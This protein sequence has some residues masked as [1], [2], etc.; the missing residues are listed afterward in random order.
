MKPTDLGAEEKVVATAWTALAP[1]LIV[2]LGASL[3]LVRS[4][5]SSRVQ[6]AVVRP[7]VVE[8]VEPAEPAPSPEVSP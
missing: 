4:S 1:V 3:F 6:A 2:L 7:G 8:Q 5:E